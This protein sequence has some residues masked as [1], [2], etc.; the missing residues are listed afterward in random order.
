MAASLMSRAVGPFF[1]L[2]MRAG[3]SPTGVCVASLVVVGNRWVT[4]VI[5]PVRQDCS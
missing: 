2:T 1:S 5:G 3:A 4:T